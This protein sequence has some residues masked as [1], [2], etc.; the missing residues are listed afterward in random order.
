MEQLP[1][2]VE[3]TRCGTVIE[4]FGMS[5]EEIADA[6]ARRCAVPDRSVDLRYAG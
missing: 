2:V 1:T 3:C 6:H 5:E 4:G